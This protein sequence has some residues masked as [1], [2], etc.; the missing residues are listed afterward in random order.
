MCNE[1]DPPK[2][3]KEFGKPQSVLVSAENEE[4]S[5]SEVCEKTKSNFDPSKQK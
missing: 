5:D 1:N 2:K 3:L 4:I